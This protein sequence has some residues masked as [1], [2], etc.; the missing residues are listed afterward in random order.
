MVKNVAIKAI[1]LILMP[2]FLAGAGRSDAGAQ[3]LERYQFR[4]NH[5]GSQFTV[6]LYCGSEEEAERVSAGAFELIE[7]INRVMSDYLPE[8]ELNRLSATSGTNRMVNVSDPLFEILRTAGKISEHT[9]G[10]FDVTIGP[11]TRA[12]RMTRMMPEP[13]LP[14]ERELEDLLNRIGYQSIRLDEEKTGV[15][16]E[17]GGMRLDLGGIAKGYAA[18]RAVEYMKERGVEIS[19]LDAGGDITL[20]DAP[21]GRNHW[22]V[23]IPVQKGGDGGHIRLGLENQTVTTSGDMFQYVV[24]DGVRYS[25]IIVPQTGV[26]STRQQQASV[27]SENGM[28][29]D[30]YASALTLMDPEDGIRLIES[31]PNTEAVIFVNLNDEIV[32]YE[33]TGFSRYVID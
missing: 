18:E 24:I 32:R 25:H 7:Q 3:G 21:P 19:L 10:L 4:S 14:D 26:G 16:L 15:L 2:L 27:I 13:E 17:K 30:A 33:S 6:I 29:A 22:E 1:C 8:S 28:Y 9:D 31:V 20:G 5:M 11:L 23:A 12:W